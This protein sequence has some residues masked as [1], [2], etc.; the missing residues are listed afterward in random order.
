MK[1]LIVLSVVFAL[2]AGAAFAVDIGGDV[3]GM[4]DI[5]KGDSGEDSKVGAGG[6][7]GGTRRVSLVASAEDENGVFGGW[8][9]LQTYGYHPD[10]D[11]IR[12]TGYVWWKPIEQVKIQ[13]GMNP[14]GFYGKDGV[15]G[16]GFYQVGGDTDVIKETWQFGGNSFYGG[17]SINGLLLTL[18]PIENLS[19]FFG[20]PYSIGGEAKDVY[21]QMHA[22]VAYDIGGVGQ[23]ALSYAGGLG[24]KHNYNNKGD[25]DGANG[26]KIFAYFGLSAIEN[27]GVD[28]GLG[29]TMSV[30]DKDSEDV[31][32]APLAVGLGL[33]FDAGAFGI[34]AR[35]QAKL[36]ETFTPKGGSE[37]KGPTI[38]DFDILP[39][40]A[41]SDT[42]TA[43]L[44]AGLQITSPDEGDSTTGWHI[45][46]Y[47]S[48][49]SSWWAP[50][51]Y[52]GLR[53]ESDGVKG[54][55]S[56]GKE[57]DPIIKWSVPIGI[58]FG[59]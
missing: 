52:A 33:K 25:F 43:L 10:D 35:A 58:A 32:N 53:I 28:I 11:G 47:V 59:F 45:E 7:P 19:I 41:V 6:W 5:I 23:V 44:S 36:G 48:V 16:W 21:G 40:F 8:A 9:R 26:G 3:I 39:S 31:Y 22:Q 49:K 1:K 29:Y 20:I 38:I 2:V 34:K 24:D 12:T 27:L 54:K 51:F 55:D 57:T 13:L 14:D 42:V 18:T 4:A 17:Y 37:K 30:K 46:P 56:A 50:N 15:T